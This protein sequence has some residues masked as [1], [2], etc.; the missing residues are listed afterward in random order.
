MTKRSKQSIAADKLL[1]DKYRQ[2]KMFGKNKTPRILTEEGFK[3]NRALLEQSDSE[4]GWKD[5][6]VFL[7]P[8]VE[9]SVE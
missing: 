6:E 5:Q 4:D 1:D 2:K 9:D 3:D 7:A 8:D